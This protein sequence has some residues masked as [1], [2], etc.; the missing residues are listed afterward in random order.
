MAQ[1][2]KIL[3]YIHRLPLLKAV[4]PETTQRWAQLYLKE[5]TTFRETLPED[6]RNVFHL[7]NDKFLRHQLPEKDSF[8]KALPALEDDEEFDEFRQM[9][10]NILKVIQVS[11]FPFFFFLE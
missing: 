10:R 11:L 6:E 2:A 5:Y 9:L 4:T 3:S 1:N 8:Q 7:V